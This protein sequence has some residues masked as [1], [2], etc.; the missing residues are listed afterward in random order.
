MCGVCTRSSNVR[1]ALLKNKN[2]KNATT[3][4]INSDQRHRTK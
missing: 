2:E 1:T 4:E 3:T